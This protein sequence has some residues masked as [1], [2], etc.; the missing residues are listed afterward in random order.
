LKE[1]IDGAAQTPGGT[2]LRTSGAHGPVTAQL[3]GAYVIAGYAKYPAGAGF[4]SYRVG[5]DWFED[6]KSLN[7]SNPVACSGAAVTRL[8]AQ[9]VVTGQ[10]TGAS[11]SAGR[12][13][14]V[15]VGA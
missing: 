12:L 14:I 1:R 8:N 3:G 4:V 11:P 2:E 5:G 6:S 9:E 13:A 7:A 10:S 15:R